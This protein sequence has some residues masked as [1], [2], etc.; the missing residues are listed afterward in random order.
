MLPKEYGGD[1]DL[2]SLS[3]EWW[4]KLNDYKKFFEEEEKYG[5]AEGYDKLKQ[6][7][8]L[9]ED[10]SILQGTEGSFRQLEFD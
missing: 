10:T 2:K 3:D 8:E 1:C 7:K 5:V 4:Q 9:I 6:V